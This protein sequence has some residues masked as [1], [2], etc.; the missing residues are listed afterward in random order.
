MNKE[1]ENFLESDEKSRMIKYTGKEKNAMLAVG[2]WFNPFSYAL[3]Y[4]LFR[5]LRFMSLNTI[6]LPIYRMCGAKIGKD[7]YIGID[8]IIDP[9]YP[10]LI[11]IGDNSILGWGCRILT[12]EGYIRHR[13]IGRVKIGN[14]TIIGAFVTIRAGV[15]IGDNVIIAMG[16]VVHK[17]V[18]SNQIVG[19]VPARKIKN[20]KEII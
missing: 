19:G 7:C 10:Q 4:V 3:R 2:E 13:R 9:A 12:H 14:N 1:V 8:A 6:S 16:A 20:L 11:T 15:T 17:D 18:P 5:I